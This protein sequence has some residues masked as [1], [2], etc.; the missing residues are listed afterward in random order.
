MKQLNTLDR[1]IVGAAAVG[2]VALFLPWYEV[3][4]G[5]LSVTGS[6]GFVGSAGAA[7]L[8][9]AGALLL[10]R[11]AGGSLLSGAN[12][13]PSALVA[14]LA[15]VGLVLVIVRWATLPRYH[16]RGAEVTAS[17]GLYLALIAGIVETAAALLALGTA[18]E[19]RPW[20]EPAP[21]AEK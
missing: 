15:A 14:G 13:G 9:A 19:Q 17:Y 1:V 6:G 2:F 7:C 11:R 3:S 16:A 20:D 18:G 10:Y 12:A 4:L 5:R 8:T 21:E